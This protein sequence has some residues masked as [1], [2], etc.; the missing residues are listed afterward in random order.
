MAFPSSPTNGQVATVGGIT[1]TYNSTKTAWARTPSLGANISVFSTVI[2]GT[3]ASTTT[4]TGALQVAGGVGI[5]G[6]A[7]VGG[8][9]QV[10]GVL[11]V[12]GNAVIGGNVAA[13]GSITSG[14]RVLAT[15]AFAAAMSVA[16]S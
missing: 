8:N 13:T 2:T 6:N 1:Y 14:G 7:V 15:Q 11:G 12:G 5:Q 4:T 9:I 3:T 16:L 10:A